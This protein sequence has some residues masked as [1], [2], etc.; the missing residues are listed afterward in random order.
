HIGDAL[1][2]TLILASVDLYISWLFTGP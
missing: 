2:M 1:D